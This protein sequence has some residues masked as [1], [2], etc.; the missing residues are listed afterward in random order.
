MLSQNSKDRHKMMQFL[1][2]GGYVHYSS[3]LCVRAHRN[4]FVEINNKHKEN[5]M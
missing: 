3:T 2:G 1:D 5:T 4:A